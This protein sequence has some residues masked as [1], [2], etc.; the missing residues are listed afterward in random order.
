[1][2]PKKSESLLIIKKCIKDLDCFSSVI[3]AQRI[4]STHFFCLFPSPTIPVYVKFLTI[5]HYC[6]TFM[7][8]YLNAPLSVVLYGT[9]C[10]PSYADKLCQCG[11]KRVDSLSRMIPENPYY[12]FYHKLWIAILKQ[13]PEMMLGDTI[14]GYLC[15]PF[16]TNI[17]L[18]TFFVF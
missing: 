9:Y 15:G 12:N 1:M 8:M 18:Y 17:G 2:R 14:L 3:Q 13:L 10:T 7:L 5:S 11:Q 16:H 6:S 4:C